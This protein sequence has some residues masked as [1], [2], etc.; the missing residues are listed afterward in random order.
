ME[1]KAMN[2]YKIEYISKENFLVSGEVFI[3][4]KDTSYC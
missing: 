3:G 1:I 4:P 2:Y